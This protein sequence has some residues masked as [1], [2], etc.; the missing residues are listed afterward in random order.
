MKEKLTLNEAIEISQK[1]L[2]TYPEDKIQDLAIR[3]DIP[4]ADKE[5]LTKQI[6]R[7]IIVSNATPDMLL[8]NTDTKCRVYLKRLNEDNIKKKTDKIYNSFKKFR[9][10]VTKMTIKDLKKMFKMYDEIFFNNDLSDYIESQN[11]KLTFK[12]DGEPTF[13][14]ESICAVNTD[15]RI[16]SYI[17]TIPL[18]KFRPGSAIVGGK[19]CK[20][21]L[22]S[23]Q[24]AF[25]HELTHLIVFMFCGDEKIS[26]QHGRLFMNMVSGLFGQTDYRHYIF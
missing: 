23:L 21:Q 18:E 24:R 10:D 19:M 16:C 12:T 15:K 5:T 6:A 9:N 22:Y 25:E 1:D 13:T 17:I 2:M 14:T 11:Y 20:D 3:L 26:E 4:S 7:K 8:K